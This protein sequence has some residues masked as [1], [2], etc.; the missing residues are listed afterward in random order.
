MTDETAGPTDHMVQVTPMFEFSV[1]VVAEDSSGYYFVR[2][3]RAVPVTV[4]AKDRAEA[5]TKVFASMG[6][7]RRGWN[8][9]ARVQSVRDVADA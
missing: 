6:A 5:L 4:I 2:W 1:E 8:W 9:T 3:D 7:A